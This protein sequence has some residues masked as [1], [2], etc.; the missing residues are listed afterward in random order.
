M[1]TFLIVDSC[2]WLQVPCQIQRFLKGKVY[3]LN[4]EFPLFKGSKYNFNL[5]KSKVLFIM[6]AKSGKDFSFGYT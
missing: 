2:L 1:C 4:I 6:K 5:R 3:I